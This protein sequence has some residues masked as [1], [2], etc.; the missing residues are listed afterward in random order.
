MSRPCL[1]VSEYKIFELLKI[2]KKVPPDGSNR[3]S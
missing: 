1:T 3:T 2:D